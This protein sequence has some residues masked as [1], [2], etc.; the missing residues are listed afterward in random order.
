LTGPRIG[1]SR[2]LTYRG[3]KP[4]I[5]F[6]AE[7]GACFTG[8]MDPSPTPQALESVRQ[9]VMAGNK[10]Q[11]IKLYREMTGT[12]LAEAKR[13]VEDLEAQWRAST[14]LGS[15]PPKPGAME[16]KPSRPS[17]KPEQL[18][19]VRRALLAHEKLEAI[20]LYR[21]ATNLG[22]AEA[23]HAVEALEARWT[24]DANASGPPVKGAGGSKPFSRAGVGSGC[25]GLILMAG[26]GLGAA[27]YAAFVR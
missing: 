24:A 4:D 11:A 12:G 3:A 5:S 15:L 14:A 8:R 23:K 21:Q 17:L 2:D 10:I 19:S 22:L 1:T 26:A 6:P 25:F 16:W 9:A 20:R 13:A 7:R 18:D 27:W